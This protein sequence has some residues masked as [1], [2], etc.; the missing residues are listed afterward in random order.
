[1]SS[2]PPMVCYYVFFA[3]NFDVLFLLG[4][5][6][7]IKVITTVLYKFV[8]SVLQLENLFFAFIMSNLRHIYHTSGLMSKLDF[9]VYRLLWLRRGVLIGLFMFIFR[10]AVSR[11][12]TARWLWRFTMST[13]TALLQKMPKITHS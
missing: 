6:F 13:L 9:S 2:R 11:T 3:N 8:F 12:E 7:N 4:W 10:L 1:M 5:N